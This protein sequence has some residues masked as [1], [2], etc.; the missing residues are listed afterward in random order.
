QG[1]LRGG[2]GA[3]APHGRETGG[4]SWGGYDHPDPRRRE[5]EGT[6]RAAPPDDPW[7]FLR[8]ASGRQ[9]PGLGVPGKGLPLE[10]PD[11]A[12]LQ[13][14]GGAPES[15]ARLRVQPR[16]RPAGQPRLG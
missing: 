9:A 7:T 16:R 12:A 13:D 1:R 14:P 2:N 11:G 5:W 15:G 10:E 6:E 4:P 3:L 8:L